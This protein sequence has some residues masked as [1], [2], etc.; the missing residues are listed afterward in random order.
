M[1]LIINHQLNPAFNLALEEYALQH[2]RGNIII[3]WRNQ[4]AVIVGRNQNTM[5]EVNLAYAREQGIAVIRRQ[6]G[7]GAVY[8][9]LGNINYTMVKDGRGKD[10]AT[11]LFM[12]FL[13]AQGLEVKLE[14]RN[15]LLL[16]GAKFSGHAL[17]SHKNRH[18]HHGCILF[19][20]DLSQLGQVLTPAP[21]KLSH[22][23]V[24]SVRAR[25]TCL[26]EHLSHINSP[27]AFIAALAA[28]WQQYVPA[29]RL[30]G[31]EE[32]EIAAVKRL[33]DDKYSQWQWNIGT[34][35][36]CSLQASR[37]FDFGLVQLHMRVEKGVIKQLQLFGD[38]FSQKDK[39]ELERALTGLPLQAEVLKQALEQLDISQ[40]INGM[41]CRQMLNMLGC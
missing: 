15:D 34:S 40:Y 16:H 1:R 27:E 28:Y 4:P 17:A 25:V 33:A 8:H 13:A 9:D 3:L 6:S 14:G 7:G 30:T 23:G 35:P 21:A 26:A 18:M 36:A 10:T 12:D 31:L 38:F 39:V 22:K 19:S 37:K 2:M 5:A 29:L 32:N 41:D 24:A 20:T 11:P